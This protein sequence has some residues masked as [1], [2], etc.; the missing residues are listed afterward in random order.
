ME[1]KTRVLESR[2]PE[3]IEEELGRS[4]ENI[5]SSIGEKIEIYRREKQRFSQI[6]SNFFKQ[7]NLNYVELRQN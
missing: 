7:K 6:L 4:I 5:G 2:I 3:V 1:I